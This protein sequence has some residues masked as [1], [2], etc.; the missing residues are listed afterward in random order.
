MQFLTADSKATRD[1]Q[2]ANLSAEQGDEELEREAD[3]A[4]PHADVVQRQRLVDFCNILLNSN[5]F[6]YIE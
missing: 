5:E 2:L 6:L 3:N 1:L 4:N